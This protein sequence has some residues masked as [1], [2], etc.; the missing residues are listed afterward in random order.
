MFIGTY[1]KEAS[2]GI[3]SL[4][5][6]GSTGNLGAP[7]LAAEAPNP[8]FIAISPDRGLIYAVCAGPAWA[9]SFRI[10]KDRASLT[11]I[12]QGIPGTGPTPCH[13]CVDSTV[14]KMALAANYH[15]GLAAAIPSPRT[16]TLARARV[17]AHE[18]KGAAPDAPDGVP[19]PLDLLHPRRQVCAR[20]RPWPGP[21]LH[22][23]DRP[24]ASRSPRGRRRSSRPRPVRARGTSRLEGTAS[25]PTSSTSFRQHDRRV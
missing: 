20:L 11:P 24:R 5:L 4:S 21:H 17:V 12:R 9:S 8:T 16:G 1:T 25:R 22:L 14:G 2:R 10:G 7:Q 3:Y 18:G 19:R 15:L 23:R 13:I 6:D